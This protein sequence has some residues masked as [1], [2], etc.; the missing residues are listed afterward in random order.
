MQRSR[1]WCQCRAYWV[2]VSHAVWDLDVLIWVLVSVYKLPTTIALFLSVGPWR[3]CIVVDLSLRALNSNIALFL[4]LGPRRLNIGVGLSLRAIDDKIALFL[5]LGPWR[6]DF[7][8]GLSL[9]KLPTTTLLFVSSPHQLSLEL[10]VWSFRNCVG[11]VSLI[12][13]DQSDQ[14]GW[15][16]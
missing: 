12:C 7:S 5:S 3:L 15:R 9:Y 13:Y 10:S 2:L 16:V 8:V 11:P 4:S 1:A 14:Y 6:L